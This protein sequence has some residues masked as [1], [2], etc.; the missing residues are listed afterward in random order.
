MSSI[1]MAT[2]MSRLISALKEKLA[3]KPTFKVVAMPDFYLDYIL[4]YP[5]KL[6]DMAKAMVGVA[7]RGGGNI[8]GWNHLV[9]RGGNASNFSAQLLKLG[10]NVAPIIETDDFGKLAI[11][12]F[13]KGANLS[14]IS[15]TGALSRT[16]AFE[17]EY[18]GRHVNIMASDPGSLSS[19]GPE[20]LSDLDEKLIREADFVCV[21]N[22]NQNSKGT[23]LAEKVFQIAKSEGKGV[24][25]FD[26]GDPT[27]RA[28][29]IPGLNERVLS[30]GFVDVLSVNEN[31]LTQLASAVTEETG[32][33]SGEEENPLFQAASVFSMLGNRVDLH[34]PAFSATFVDGQRE[35]VLCA[36]STPLKVTGAGDAW[37]A[38]DILAQGIGLDHR[39]RLVFANATAA[40]Y[41]RKPDLDPCSLDE[42]LER[43]AEIEKLNA[44]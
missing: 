8:L 9:G 23:E 1:T 35:R 39:E 27:S 14:H 20:K 13:L 43:V 5:G 38:G 33:F 25:F 36:N 19:F 41:M 40:A 18:S 6:D 10:A 4:A 32:E 2:K 7:E 16:L 29:D 3:E 21:F 12:H 15:S 17:A 42:I 31:E 28:N 26:P 34:T 11:T 24:T 44:R 37:N 30:K 22:W